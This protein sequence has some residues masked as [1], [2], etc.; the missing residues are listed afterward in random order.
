MLARAAMQQLGGETRVE[1]VPGASQ[2]FVEP[3][4]PE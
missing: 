4:A 1:I 3:G 2:M